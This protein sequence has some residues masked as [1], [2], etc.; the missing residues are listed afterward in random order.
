[1]ASQPNESANISEFGTSSTRTR[2]ATLN[3]LIVVQ[4]YEPDFQLA[5][6]QARAANHLLEI[7]LEG[8]G[9]KDVATACLWYALD[10]GVK[11]LITTPA[12]DDLKGNLETPE[13]AFK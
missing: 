3:D 9:N 2:H 4:T 10:Q 5:V 12:I 11:V 7:K 6:E 1:M 8:Y 13:A